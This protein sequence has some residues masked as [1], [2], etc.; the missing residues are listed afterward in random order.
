MINNEDSLEEILEYLFNVNEDLITII[1]FDLI[2]EILT[3]LILLNKG[4]II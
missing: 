4:I 2:I 1:R 3:L